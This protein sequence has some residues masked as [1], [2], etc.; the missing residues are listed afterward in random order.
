MWF[1]SPFSKQIW[2]LS[3]KCVLLPWGHSKGLCPWFFFHQGGGLNFWL[4]VQHLSNDLRAK[5]NESR[6][7]TCGKESQFFALWLSLLESP[8]GPAPIRSNEIRSAW[9]HEMMHLHL[10][11]NLIIADGHLKLYKAAGSLLLVLPTVQPPRKQDQI[12]I[13]REALPVTQETFF[14]FSLLKY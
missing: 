7:Y 6:I 9:L 8:S 14:Q 3:R 13:L 10:R 12:E 11:V 4:A 2:P 5:I 1:R